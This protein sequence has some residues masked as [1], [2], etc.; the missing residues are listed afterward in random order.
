[1]NKV[2]ELKIDS[3]LWATPAKITNLLDFKPEKLSVETKSNTNNDIKVHQ[4]RYENGGFYLTIDDI[5]GYFNFSNNLGILTMIFNNDNQ[6]NKYHQIWKEIL[7]IINKEDGEL[8]LHEKIKITDSDLPIEHVFKIPS[9][10]I[11][12]KSF[13]EKNNTFYLEHSLNHCLYEIK[14]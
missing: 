3:T 7:K 13:I 12:I 6:K 8:V 2:R 11:V 4:V 9:I 14:S 1:M 10:T 5:R